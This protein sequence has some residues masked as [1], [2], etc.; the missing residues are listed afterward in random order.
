MIYTFLWNARLPY[1]KEV[2]KIDS[3]RY[4]VFS[5]VGNLPWSLK[6]FIGAVSDTVRVI[7]L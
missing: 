5:V 3:N 1:S 7:F 4:Q 6:A 2:L